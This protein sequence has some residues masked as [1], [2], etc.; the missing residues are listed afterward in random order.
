MRKSI[1]IVIAGLIAINLVIF[2]RADPESDEQD[3]A[4][5]RLLS[6]M[7]HA[8]PL[9]PDSIASRI[10]S[11]DDP[12]LVMTGRSTRDQARQQ[13]GPGAR[14]AQERGAQESGTTRPNH[15]AQEVPLA[16]A[17]ASRIEQVSYLDVQREVQQQRAQSKRRRPAPEYGP[18]P[19]HA[20]SVDFRGQRPLGGQPVRPQGP[21]SYLPPSQLRSTQQMGAQPS[22]S[23]LP[24]ES[25]PAFYRAAMQ[26]AH[27]HIPMDQLERLTPPG[28]YRPPTP[29]PSQQPY[30]HQPRASHVSQGEQ[31]PNRSVPTQS[32]QRGYSDSRFPVRLTQSQAE[33]ED[34]LQGNPFVPAPPGYAPPPTQESVAPR[35]AE[36]S[37]PTQDF[38]SSQQPEPPA[39]RRRLRFP[40]QEPGEYASSSQD[41]SV[42]VPAESAPSPN[43]VRSLEQVP[44]PKGAGTTETL[45]SPEASAPATPSASGP[46]TRQ[47]NSTGPRADRFAPAEDENLLRPGPGSTGT[48]SQSQ[49]NGDTS[50]GANQSPFGRPN[51]DSTNA[52]P[53][54]AT[55][56]NS[57]QPNNGGAVNSNSAPTH[58]G[59]N[60]ANSPSADSATS[61]IGDPHIDV[62]AKSQYPSARECG[63]CHKQIF[64]EWSVSNHAYAAVSPMFHRFEQTI[65]SLSRGT[66]GYFC[67]RCHAT[68][69]TALN[70][71]RDKSIWDSIPAAHEG[72]TCITCHRVQEHYGKVNGDRRIEKGGVSAP[73]FG[74]GYGETLR[75]VIA[76][77]EHYKVKTNPAEKGPGQVI[78][79]RV[80]HFEQ[81]SQSD[82]CVSCHQVAVYPG[83]ALEV[84]WAQYRASPACKE[85]I[86]CQDCH[87]GSV[88]GKAYGYDTAPIAE[89]GGKEIDPGRK[90][91]NHM[92][93]GPGYSIAHP[94]VF[95]FR[96]KKVEDE[97][98]TP[99]EWN[100]FDYRAGWGTD[101]FEKAVEDGYVQAYF[102]SVWENADDRV[103]AREL[104]DKNL[105][106]LALKKELRHQLM[107]GNSKVQGPIFKR[108][109]KVGKKLNFKYVIK[110]LSSGHNMPSGSLGAQPQLWV[111]VALTGPDGRH[112]WESGY[113]DCNGDIADLHSMEVAKRRIKPDL[114]LVN[115]QTKF[116]IQ[117]VKG[118]DREM[119]LPIPVD[120]DQLPFIRPAGLPITV[121][122]HPP[123][124]RMEAHSVPPLGSKE[125]K[126]HVP[127]RLIQQPGVY[128]LHVR[129]RS[130]AEP[131]YFMRFCR[132]TPEMERRMNERMLNYH[133]QT[134]S[135]IV[136]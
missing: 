41:E 133:E 6:T 40:D 129:L 121:L 17:A 132:A 68:V 81:I 48:P 32:A 135:F 58:S 60:T 57:P 13:R 74:A 31:V 35:E 19:D 72:V 47:N 106:K 52:S 42:T 10:D 90:H 79:N 67:M 27:G 34:L 105:Q 97:D 100:Q 11:Y 44:T 91:S 116:L 8:K 24:L 22:P 36:T 3:A 56:P 85:G 49:Q 63:E 130:R 93:V 123:T 98:W 126:Y 69:A 12:V 1:P 128:Q 82:F 64:E 43:S 14:G 46:S 45:P 120:Q 53:S 23:Q 125:A 83:I 113:V 30:G 55:Q 70:H 95:P 7:S 101:D 92:F 50:G 103:D 112:L 51:G 37:G 114:Q 127:A 122:N 115:L 118:P 21:S 59:Q 78:H 109:P 16:T 117:H 111:N 28:P 4:P 54:K 96:N 2:Q 104:L 61:V 134:T 66:I 110:N 119:Y 86:S 136:R 26:L 62:F 76:K 107:D 38:A 102:P 108:Q 89:L 25:D 29:S 99:K 84:V 80:I 73:V 94:G 15:V 20:P 75:D 88:P 9:R 18:A 33:V 124:I 65:N 71:P 39:A 77:K 131:I 87:M 5:P